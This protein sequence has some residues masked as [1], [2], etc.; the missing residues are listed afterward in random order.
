MQ[1]GFSIIARMPCQK[2]IYR[3]CALIRDRCVSVIK[4]GFKHN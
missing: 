2:I 1:E 4:F 3:H